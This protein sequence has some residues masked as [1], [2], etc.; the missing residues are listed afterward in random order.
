MKLCLLRTIIKSKD[1]SSRSWWKL[2]NLQRSRW[3]WTKTFAVARNFLGSWQNLRKGKHPRKFHR[4][5]RETYIGSW[6]HFFASL[7]VNRASGESQGK[8][9]Q[10]ISEDAS[11]ESWKPSWRNS[12]E[13]SRRNWRNNPVEVLKNIVSKFNLVSAEIGSAF[14]GKVRN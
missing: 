9:S 1:I 10:M 7:F 2:W 12:E 11:G 5:F 4:K 8:K 13:T 3:S 6:W 14:L